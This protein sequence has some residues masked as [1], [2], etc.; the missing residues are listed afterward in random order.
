MANGC[1]TEDPVAIKQEA[2]RH[3]QGILCSDEPSDSHSEYL[4]RLDGFRW[5]PQHIDTLNKSISNEEIK[6][7]IF[8][9]DDSKAP[10]PDGFS[11]RFSRRLGVLLE[12]MFTQ[13]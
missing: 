7:A 6:A 10:G 9:I 1:R 11:S 3:F 13:L 5:S 4:N 2:V 8:S 12:M